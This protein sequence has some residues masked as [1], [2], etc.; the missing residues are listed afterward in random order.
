MNNF[1][2]LKNPIHFIA[3]LGWN[4][5]NSFCSRNMGFLILFFI[6]YSSFPLHQYALC[7]FLNHFIFYLDM[8]KASADL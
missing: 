2:N 3:T 5:Q 6:I 1:P 8:W 7:C 4:W